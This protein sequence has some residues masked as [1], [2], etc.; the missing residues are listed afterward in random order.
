MVGRVFTQNTT[1]GLW[2]AGNVGAGGVTPSILSQPKEYTTSG[3]AGGAL[4]PT[5]T[6]LNEQEGVFL[7]KGMIVL[8]V[9]TTTTPSLG[10]DLHFQ[11]A[12]GQIIAVAPGTAVASGNQLLAL[13][14][15]Y[16]F[17]QPNA[18]GLILANL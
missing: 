8:Q 5:L 18:N 3:G 1:S 14:A 17:P 10:D 13:G 7:S 9:L 12:D 11:Q 6:M 4:T 2:G 16:M 15:V